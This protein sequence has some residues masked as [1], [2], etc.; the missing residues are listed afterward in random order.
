MHFGNVISGVLLFAQDRLN[1]L[2][3]HRKFCRQDLC[4]QITEA[5]SVP[6]CV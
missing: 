6:L 4:Q 3:I 1:I 2:K 5:I